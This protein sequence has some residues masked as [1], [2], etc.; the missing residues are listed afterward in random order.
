M[1]FVFGVILASALL[2]ASALHR[3]GYPWWSVLGALSL[4]LAALVIEALIATRGGTIDPT[5]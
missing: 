3:G 4:P 5:E 1:R 2:L